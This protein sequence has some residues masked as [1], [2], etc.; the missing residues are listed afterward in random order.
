[1]NAMTASWISSKGQGEPTVRANGIISTAI[2][3]G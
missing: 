1:M 2:A 3:G